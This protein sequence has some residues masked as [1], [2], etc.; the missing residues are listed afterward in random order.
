MNNGS[1]IILF[2]G[3]VLSITVYSMSLQDLQRSNQKIAISAVNR[4]DMESLAGA[5]IVFV[6]D[7]LVIDTTSSMIVSSNISLFEGRFSFKAVRT[8][9]DTNAMANILLS[10]TTREG[11]T[12][13][14]KVFADTAG[15]VRHGF[16]KFHRGKWHVRTIFAGVMR[17]DKI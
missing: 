3:I 7:R 10:V 2:I 6:L 17:R 5:A 14:F 9:C 12:Q 16:R 11:F 15:K 1:R 13:Q 4:V 8:V